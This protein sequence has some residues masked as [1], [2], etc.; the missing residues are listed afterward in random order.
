MSKNEIKMKNV[1]FMAAYVTLNP[2]D[3]LLASE[4][5]WFQPFPSFLWIPIFVYDYVTLFV[6]KSNLSWVSDSASEF[7][8]WFALG[9]KLFVC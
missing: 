2:Y 1:I 7:Y 6:V 5:L 9:F 8:P 4:C 3:I